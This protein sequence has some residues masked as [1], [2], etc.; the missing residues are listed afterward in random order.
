MLVDR[1]TEADALERLLAAV[2]DGLSGVLVL[3]GQPGIGKTAL[4]DWGAGQAGDMQVARLVGVESEMDLSFAGLHQLLVPFLGGLERLPG[5]Q[6]KALE[7]AFGLAAGPP[8]DRF[9]VGLAALTLITGAAA[10]R[11]VLCVIDDAQWLDQ[12]SV[13]V[14]GFVAR[15]LFADRVGMLFAVRA[16]EQRA[17]VLEGLSE[18]TVGAL[19]EK[20]AVELL[21]AS[22]GRPVDLRV[23]ARIVAE[24][25][26]NPLA[27]VEVGG[28]LTAAEASG[29]VVL[30]E[31]LRF[32]GHLEELYQSRIRALPDQARMLVL[33]AAAD[34]TGEPATVWRAAAELGI[35]LRTGELPAVERLVTWAPAVQFRHPLM[36]SAAYYAAPARARRRAHQALAAASDPERDPDRRAWHLAEAATG[37]DEPIAAEL[38]RSADRARCRGGWISQATFLERA[39][40]LTPEPVG[41]A[42]RLLGAAEARLVAGEAPAVQALLDRAAPHIGDPLAR[43]RARRLEGLTLYAAGKRDEATSVLVDAAR[44]LQ[45]YDPRLARETLVDAFAAAQWLG[46]SSAGIAE[47]LD[48]VH[49]VPTVADAQATMADLLL[50]G[51]AALAERR[52]EAGAALLRRAIAPLNAD[53]GI[54]DDVLPHFM[55]LTIAASLLYDDAARYQLEHRWVPELRD[56]GALAAVLAA[57]TVQH[58]VQVDEGR[59]ADAEASLAEG[60]ELSEA[61]GYRAYLSNFAFVVEL[62]A[63]AR[64]GREADARPLADRLLR[65]S[66]GQGGE[67]AVRGV[68]L[69]LAV[70]ELGLGNYADALRHGL[71]SRA[72]QAGV[73]FAM[74]ADVVEAGTRCGDRAAAVAALEDFTPWAIATGSHWALGLLARCRALLA[75]DDQAEPQYRLA[76]EHLRQTR[77]AP[78][79]A[80]AR[81][82]YGEWLRRQ[83]RRRDARD[84]LRTAWQA[85]DAMGVEAFA[86]RARAELRATGEHARKRTVETVD[87]LTPQEAQIARLA[88]EGVTNGEIAARLFISASTVEYHLRKVFRKLGITSRAR[89]AHALREKEQA[90]P[91]TTRD[92]QWVPGRDR[93][94]H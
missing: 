39:A 72:P 77:L 41:R 80:R 54:L 2:R 16:G 10:D 70:L 65:E 45:R 91:L 86:E 11:A 66:A 60:R 30:A 18:L 24:T 20:A 23:G 25:A 62:V 38:E 90:T 7:S 27:L 74:P 76:I 52:Y 32:G 46:Q 69:A 1:V 4:L 68:H 89:L 14:L 57:L 40:A 67:N 94:A 93:R 29:Q 51:F 83:R 88:A 3:R 71:E 28:E 56:R 19:P 12:V 53:Q 9:L 43:A 87:A 92:R 33:V 17:V 75:D 48:A 82:V 21:A 79:L 47:V 35:D 13:E 84:Q 8:P 85:F 81:L 26:G 44:M 15:R 6:S 59:F 49:S 64:R 42:R 61:T 78:E 22:A 55:S 58:A 34:P 63:L 37:P 50:D 73:R 31:P 36:R 5:P